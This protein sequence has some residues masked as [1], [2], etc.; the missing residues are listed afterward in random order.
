[1]QT[2]L[3]YI[4]KHF[5]KKKR[6]TNL[7]ARENKEC[8]NEPLTIGKLMKSSKKSKPAKKSSGKGCK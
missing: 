5:D 2:S 4:T 7:V 8:Y 3:E 1:M 6:K